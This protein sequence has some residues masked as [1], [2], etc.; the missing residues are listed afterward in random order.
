MST[1]KKLVGALITPAFVDQIHSDCTAVFMANEEMKSA[2]LEMAGQVSEMAQDLSKKVIIEGKIRG[3]IQAN[4]P[5]EH[6]IDVTSSGSSACLAYTL[7]VLMS[8]TVGGLAKA[9][10]DHGTNNAVVSAAF[11][12]AISEMFDLLPDAEEAKQILNHIMSL[13]CKEEGDDKDDKSFSVEP[14]RKTGTLH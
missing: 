9:S 5:P 8:S 13:I 11:M 7:G 1:E 3:I 4:C 2:I 12:M 6:I 10:Q 14:M